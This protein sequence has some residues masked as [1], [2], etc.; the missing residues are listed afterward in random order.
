MPSICLGRDITDIPVGVTDIIRGPYWPC[1]V[2]PSCSNLAAQTSRDLLHS[3][4]ESRGAAVDW[5]AMF[6]AGGRFGPCLG[7]IHRRVDRV[8]AF[9]SHDHVGK[10]LSLDTFGQCPPDDD[11]RVKM[12]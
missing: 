9:Y 11:I 10:M 4:H 2:G 3:L 1:A 6:M 8:D 7:L 12:L 5:D